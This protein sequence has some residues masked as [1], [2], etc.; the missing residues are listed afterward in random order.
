VG[1]LEIRYSTYDK[2]QP[3]RPVRMKN[4][5]WGGMA[6]KMVDGSEPQPWHCLPFTEGSTYGLELV[7]QYEQDC[8]V[9]NDGGLVRFEWDYASEPGCKLQGSEFTTFFPKEASR[10]YAFNT[11]VDIKPPGG[12]VVCTLPHPRFFTDASG[13]VP[14]SMIGHVQSEWWPKK[15]FVVFKAPPPGQRHIFRKGEPYV[16][17]RFEP[18][19]ASY[20]ITKMDEQEEAARRRQEQSV[21]V[22]SPDIARNIWRNPAGYA[23]NDHYKMLARAF[24]REGMEG[25]GQTI[26]AARARRE[27]WLPRDKPIGECLDLGRQR[28]QERKYREAFAIYNLVLGRDPGNAEAANRMGIIA[29]STEKMVLAME[30]MARAVALAPGSAKYQADMGELL[31]RLGRFEEAESALRASLQIKADDPQ[32]LSNLGLTLCQQGKVSE[33]LTACRSALAIDPRSAI[34]HFRMGLILSEQRQ[35]VGARA[36]FD[37]ALALAPNFEEARR[38]LDELPVTA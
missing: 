12:Y 10:Y 29:A 36:H 24:E 6:Q 15:F 17:L 20:Q 4:S 26:D 37:A 38:R 14:I 22:S 13:T 3:P 28:E 11:G 27:D 2:A 21:V 25:I 7:Y 1:E 30:L 33:G 8:H 18:R 5:G 35:Y 31:R 32:V 19:R 23:F 9:I 34:A 16:Q